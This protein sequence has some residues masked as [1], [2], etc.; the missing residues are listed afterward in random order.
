VI[1]GAPWALA[2]VR[3]EVAVTDDES[4]VETARR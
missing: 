3:I 2:C 1:P 4:V